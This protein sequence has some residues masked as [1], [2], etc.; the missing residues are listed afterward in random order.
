MQ[1]L[2]SSDLLPGIWVWDS[3]SL[4]TIGVVVGFRSTTT[5]VILVSI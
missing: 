5:T 3:K 2:K 1:N 4:A